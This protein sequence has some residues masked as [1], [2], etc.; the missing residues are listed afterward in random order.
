MNSGYSRDS[1]LTGLWEFHFMVRGQG[2]VVFD[3]VVVARHGAQA[4]AEVR[5]L[6]GDRLISLQ[7]VRRVS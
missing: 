3:H 2:G 6:F 5:A 4:Q 1:R 7:D